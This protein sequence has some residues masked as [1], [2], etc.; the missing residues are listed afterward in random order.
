M[1]AAARLGHPK[2]WY[3][4]GEDDCVECEYCDRVFALKGGSQT[5]RLNRR[6]SCNVPVTP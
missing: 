3:D 1:E 2:V 4:M 5:A 6:L